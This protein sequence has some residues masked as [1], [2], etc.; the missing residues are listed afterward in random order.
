MGLVID[1]MNKPFV[2]ARAVTQRGERSISKAKARPAEVRL[3]RDTQNGIKC[4]V[5]DTSV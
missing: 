2:F 1:G 5:Q 3:E 4:Q